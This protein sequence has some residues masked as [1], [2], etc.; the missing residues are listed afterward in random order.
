[1]STQ[2]WKFF[3]TCTS[4]A[5]PSCIVH[6]RPPRAQAN[7]LSRLRDSSWE[8]FE[9][10]HAADRARDH[11]FLVRANDAHG[12]P[13]GIRGN[14]ALVRRVALFFEFDPKKPQPAADSGADYRYVLAD[15]AG[16]HQ[17]VQSAERCG[18]RADPFLDLVTKQ[19]DRLGCPHILRFARHQ[20]PHIRTGFGYP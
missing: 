8:P 4:A 12:D 20:V 15:A 9:L 13:A 19:G 16:E 1:M 5:W 14:Q 3:A 11:P 6:T 10:E 18:E 17:C 7:S 2:G